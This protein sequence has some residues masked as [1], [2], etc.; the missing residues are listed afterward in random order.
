MHHKYSPFVYVEQLIV[1]S[2]F[3]S[4]KH[5]LSVVSY[6]PFVYVEQLIVESCF[7]SDKHTLSVVSC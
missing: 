6:S 2:C 1:E 7:N 5:T 3:N 4:D